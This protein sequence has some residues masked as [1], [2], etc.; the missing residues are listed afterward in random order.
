M[1]LFSWLLPGSSGVALKG[2][3]ERLLPAP[4]VPVGEGGSNLPSRIPGLPRGL[5]RQAR[6]SPRV[7]PETPPLESRFFGSVKGPG[8]FGKQTPPST[9]LSQP[10]IRCLPPRGEGS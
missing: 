9:W 7:A 4:D 8:C 5:C 2:G 3:A 6:P 1:T 10:S